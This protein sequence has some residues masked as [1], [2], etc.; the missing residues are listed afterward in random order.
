[1][2]LKSVQNKSGILPSFKI[3]G[4]F[5]ILTFMAAF[6]LIPPAWTSPV[7]EPIET[8]K[9]SRPLI[10]AHRGGRKWAPE[11]TMAAFRKSLAANVDGIELDIH[12]CKTGELVVIHDES[13][14][15]TTDG[16]GL[17]K[18]KTLAELKKLSAG[19]WYGK[20]FQG[21]QLP[22]LSEVL[23][24]IDGKLVLNIEIKN[25]PIAYQGIEDDLLALLAKY[26]YPKK[27][28]ISSFDHEVLERIHKKNRLYKVAF[29]GESLFID[30]PGYAKQIGAQAWNPYYGELRT[31]S[32]E[33][34]HKVPLE[35]NVWTVNDEKQ[36]QSMTDMKVDG[37]I[38]DDPVGLT[39][40]YANKKSD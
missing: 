21:E 36:W 28:V 31:D 7:S 33:A 2:T 8:V 19:A 9:A 37:I 20:E 16:H 22:L 15:R 13:L 27:I 23:D 32:V 17:I 11:N 39:A 1:M 4:G 38:T 40:F 10:I 14:D 6:Q 25:A 29:L 18:E 24:L 34:A 12:R 30:L 35:V 5:L 26:K 3:S